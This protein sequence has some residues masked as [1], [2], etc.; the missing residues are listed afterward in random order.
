MDHE[1]VKCK[2]MVR[3]G[4]KWFKRDVQ[5]L[6]AA[7]KDG[8]CG[9][10]HPDAV[11]A[12]KAKTKARQDATTAR[13]QAKWSA[14]DQKAKDAAEAPALRATIASLTIQR[15]AA[16]ARSRDLASERDE[17]LAILLDL[18]TMQDAPS[19]RYKIDESTKSVN[20]EVG[21]L[22]R[23]KVGQYIAIV[24]RARKLVGTP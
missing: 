11:A 6:H 16:E 2:Q 9:H 20:V 18:V 1:K 22:T 21:D 7:K 8:Y 3:T 15:D 19:D 24:D 23:L 12:K 13:W 14:E 4:E 5:C 10:H 17:A